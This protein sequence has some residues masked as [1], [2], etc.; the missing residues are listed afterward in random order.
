MRFHKTTLVIALTILLLI[1]RG[2]S[3]VDQN[4][5]SLEYLISYQFFL[6]P[7]ALLGAFF[8]LIVLFVRRFDLKGHPTLVIMVVLLI[9]SLVS[10][11]S[12]WIFRIRTALF[13][14]EKRSMEVIRADH[15]QYL[16][17]LFSKPLPDLRFF[18]FECGVIETI[19]PD[20][21][22][23]PVIILDKDKKRISS[24]DL[25]QMKVDK[26]SVYLK[27]ELPP[28]EQFNHLYTRTLPFE[29]L[30][31]SG[32]YMEP[33]TD[34]YDSLGSIPAIIHVIEKPAKVDVRKVRE[35]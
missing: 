31:E 15:Y 24:R 11:N 2:W 35:K 21:I 10:T 29:C 22:I 6:F 27:L 32:G 26:G 13:P 7:L 28:K 8:S 9:V 30:L 17:K 12:A 3:D 20:L 5:K 33:M 16:S 1:L 23:D 4:T 25:A 18:E 34:E 14:V 19:Q